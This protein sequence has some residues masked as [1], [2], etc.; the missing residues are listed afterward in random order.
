MRRPDRR[1]RELLD[2][3]MIPFLLVLARSAYA[4][5]NVG[6]W[7][8]ES[9]SSAD[10]LAPPNPNTW[11]NV[12]SV[13]VDPELAL[14]SSPIV[15]Q[16][17]GN[18][19]TGTTIDFTFDGGLLNQAG[20]DFALFEAFYLTDLPTYA[21]S[22]DHDAF[23]ATFAV[24]DPSFVDTTVSYNLY[25]AFTGP[26]SGQVYGAEIDLSDLGVPEFDTV[27]VV[28]MVASNANGDPLGLAAWLCNDADL[29]GVCDAVDAC[30]DFDDA[31][32]EDGDALPDACDP[33]LGDASPSDADD[34]G[35]CDGDDVCPGFDDAD[36]VDGDGLADGCDLC[37]L[38]APDDDADDDTVCN[39]DDICPDE[40]DLA[41]ADV[42][43]VP[44][45]C[46][47][48]PADVSDDSDGDG[49]CDSDDLCP[50]ADDLDDADADGLPD[51][52]DPCPEGAGV[53]A[54][55]DG[56]CTPVDC[57][58]QDADRSP[59]ASE[60]CNGVD[61]DC[62]G[63][64][65]DDELDVDGD[66]L[67]LCAGD[68]DDAD[69]TAYPTATDVCGNGVD[70]DCDGRDALC[71]L[72]DV[73]DPPPEAGGCKCA[74]STGNPMAALALLFPLLRRRSR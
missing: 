69:S 5:E 6:T 1:R 31:T 62:D 16:G 21:L 35:V 44:D 41:D 54:D 4:S 26:Y 11:T 36:D 51:A 25:I 53:D 45:G 17:Y 9:A 15:D 24:S 43:A 47:A 63:V 66:G 73:D 12:N 33:C 52:C 39:S 50:G 19:A 64:V 28:R 2:V 13:P 72:P 46:D 27:N 38:D 67:S 8:V 61:D 40:D 22:S 42:D 65:A 60:V 56:S 58:D 3:S 70:E 32:D 59:L 34:D 30:P 37:P 55:G 57:D 23:V 48:C 68:C 14:V 71:V 74:T 7:I 18:A 10:F 49:S 29:D 20:P